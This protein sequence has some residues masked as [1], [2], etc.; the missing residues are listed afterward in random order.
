MERFRIILLIAGTA[1]AVLGGV[2]LLS[3]ING[4]NSI[5]SS[6]ANVYNIVGLSQTQDDIVY[7][8]KIVIDVNAQILDTQ[9]ITEGSIELAYD[10]NLFEVE[11]IIMPSNIIALNQKID[12][13]EGKISIQI[14]TKSSAGLVGIENLTKIIFNKLKEPGRFT[15][16]SLLH[17]STLGNPNTLDSLEKSISV[18]F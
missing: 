5:D 4:N 14:T 7:P 13:A 15:S 12:S 10:K 18:S 3:I 11:D 2:Y 6:S 9:K 17:S 1:A 16:V 8:D